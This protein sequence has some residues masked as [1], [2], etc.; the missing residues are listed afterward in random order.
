[1]VRAWIFL[2]VALW[3][4]SAFAQLNGYDE[5]FDES[6]EVRPHY[7]AIYDAWKSIPAKKR[8]QIFAKS[9]A[10]FSGD[11]YLEVLPRIIT[12]EEFENI[13]KPGIDQ[14]ARAIRAFLMDHY[15]GE[16]RYIKDQIVPEKVITRAL[17]K[18]VE[19]GYDG[20]MDPDRIAFI[21]GPDLIRDS[22]NDFRVIEDNPGYV[23]G[24]GDL[25]LAYKYLA[26]IYPELKSS[27]YK[28]PESFYRELTDVFK[29][30][31]KTHNGKVVMYFMPGYSDN[32]DPRL[33]DIFKRHGVII[34]T[35]RS[36]KQ[37]KV[38]EDGVYV[39]SKKEGFEASKERV[40]FI[41]V[42]GEHADIDPSFFEVQK[43]LIYG[44]ALAHLEKMEEGVS[45]YSDLKKKIEAVLSSPDDR[46]EIDYKKLL[47][48]LEQADIDGS[49]QE[50]IHE[51]RKLRGLVKAILDGK[52]ESSYSPGVDFIG[53]KEFY[54][55]VP[56][57]IKY[58][59]GEEVIL[60][61]IP[62]QSFADP[63]SGALRK[64]DFQK[65]FRDIK[66]N[67]I[68]PTDGRGGYGVYIGP[69]ISSADAKRAQKEVQGNP[70]NFIHQSL[71]ALSHL[72]N[73]IVDLRGYAFVDGKGVWV[74][75]HMFSRG[76][77]MDRDRNG[78]LK[79]NGKVNLSDKGRELLVL[80]DRSKSTQNLRFCSNLF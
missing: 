29:K 70:G 34:V 74:G 2:L 73:L 47:D 18:S 6:G 45:D 72:R 59:L 11:N 58:Y 43:K 53:D 44:E 17:Q 5:I 41:F 19:I 24:I 68:K 7:R 3:V 42:N 16:K 10:A 27:N 25:E 1:M 15:S 20:K 13:I 26:N 36:D 71:V 52:V 33:R 31:A 39:F 30:R 60:K 56:E 76:I 54:I 28:N 48:L 80:V 35:P 38:T 65:V 67:V 40:G 21:Y 75:D 66:N 22:N 55:Y 62:T 14:R 32:E 9:K 64:R 4:S 23:G 77:P 51:K 61:N 46:G 69:Y 49:L 12:Q 50:S 57:M 78:E 37:F 8:E 79:G 63:N